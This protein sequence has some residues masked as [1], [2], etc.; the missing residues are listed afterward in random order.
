[1]EVT[2]QPHFRCVGFSGSYKPILE[3]VME[4]LA[5]AVFPFECEI[6]KIADIPPANIPHQLL[7]LGD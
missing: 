4:G 2:S 1:M 7:H 6:F 5:P 3:T